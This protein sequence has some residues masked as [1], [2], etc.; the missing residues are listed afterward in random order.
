MNIKVYASE[1][2]KLTL[3]TIDDRLF[4]DTAIP[5]LSGDSDANRMFAYKVSQD[6]GDEANCL[7]LSVPEG[8]TRLAID[9][10]MLLGIGIRIYLE[11]ETKVGPAMPEMLYDHVIKFSPSE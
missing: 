3:V 6:C 10:G 11:P 5:Y 2:A 8:C 7:Q 9:S 1:P 4:A